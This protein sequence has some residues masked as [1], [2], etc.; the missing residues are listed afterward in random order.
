MARGVGL[1]ERPDLRQRAGRERRVRRGAT[2]QARVSGEALRRGAHVAGEY[3]VPDAVGPAVEVAVAD[4]ELLLGA[5]D[6]GATGERRVGDEPAAGV[7]R[8]A[9]AV[10]H[11]G[12]LAVDLD[13]KSVV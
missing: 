8:G 4:D 12:K 11:I 2:G 3:L 7:V 10:V 9:I 1:Q 6:H 13:R 5:V